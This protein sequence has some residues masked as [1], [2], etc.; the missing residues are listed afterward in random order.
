MDGVLV[1]RHVLIVEDE[2]LL[3]LE[4][5]DELEMMAAH[6]IGPVP[7]VGAA[8]AVIEHAR[9]IDAAIINVLLRGEPSSPVADV[10]LARGIPFLFVTGDDL[11][12]HEH[13]PEVPV[14][15]KPADIWKIVDA[16]KLLLEQRHHI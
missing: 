9:K 8:L 5:V 14:Q 12:V 10:L 3:A 4:L 1:G 7:S 15:P 16:L 2:P 13:Y 11:F 6:P